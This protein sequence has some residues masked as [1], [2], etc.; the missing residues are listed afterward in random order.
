MRGP[1]PSLLLNYVVTW[2]VHSLRRGPQ[3]R[4]ADRWLVKSLRIPICAQNLPSASALHD[5][6]DPSL[7][8]RVC[9]PR[10]PH[11]AKVKR[12]R[13]LPTL[14]R[15]AVTC[16]PATSSLPQ[17]SPFWNS[18]STNTMTC[19]AHSS[20]IPSKGHPAH[21]FPGAFS[22]ACRGSC[23]SLYPTPHSESRAAFQKWS[24]T[25]QA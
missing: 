10:A 7:P 20:G 12:S 1:P 4:T 2:I 23:W 19:P 25:T 13:E 24:K 6:W 21:F 14:P 22:E 9:A 3:E 11:G 17:D 18:S 16:R 8:G 5:H 15:G